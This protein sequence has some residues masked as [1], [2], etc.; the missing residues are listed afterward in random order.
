MMLNVITFNVN[1]LASNDASVPKRRKLFTWL[2]AHCCDIAF[3]QETHCTDSMQ[4]FLAQ[5]WGG[6]SFFSNGTSSSR[7]VCILMRRGLDIEIKEIR[8]DDQG[9]RVDSYS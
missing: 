4:R 9:M 1:G 7:G 5:E 2:K 6:Q 8:K 3:L